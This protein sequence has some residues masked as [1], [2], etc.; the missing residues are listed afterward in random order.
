MTAEN[1]ENKIAIKT[2]VHRRLHTNLYY[3]TINSLML[4]AVNT[5]KNLVIKVG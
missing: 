1:P 3:A 2:G 5:K 4:Y